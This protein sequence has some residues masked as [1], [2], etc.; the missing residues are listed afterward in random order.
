MPDSVSPIERVIRPR[1][2]ARVAYNRLSR[3]YDALSES[4]ERPG[5]HAAV[6][7]L[8]VQPGESALEVGC[9]TGHSVRALGT[10][11]DRVRGLDIS[12]GMLAVA[13]VRLRRAG[14]DGQVALEQG[15]AAKLPYAD[16][17]FDVLLMTFALELFDTPEI[18]L[19]LGECRRVLRPAGRLAVAAMSRAAGASLVLRLYEWAHRRFPASVDCRPIFARA[20]LEENGF[21][22]VRVE[23]LSM[24][25]LPVEVVL[26]RRSM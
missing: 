10:V 3:W 2:E 5:R 18:P 23:R 22:T 24:W 16:G 20:M 21:C 15:D 26:A 4:S 12:D 8:A 7:M 6:G 14:L 17:S 25:G 11:T 19:V 13:R 1:S 9:G